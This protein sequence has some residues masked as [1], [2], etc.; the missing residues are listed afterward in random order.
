MLNPATPAM[1]NLAEWLIAREA[2]AGHPSEAKVQAA[3]RAC[4]KLRHLFSKLAGVAGFRSL[5]SRALVL[6]S[7]EVPWLGT[8]E[9]KENGSLEGLGTLH[10][11]QDRDEAEKGGVILLAQLLGLLATFVGAALALR[12]VRD[13]WPDA[14]S[15]VTKFKTE[16]KP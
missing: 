4:E 11:Q 13:V 8:V 12:L 9:V 15:E 3:F 10:S 6:A 1:R 14:P 2:A 7:A 16:K 5:L